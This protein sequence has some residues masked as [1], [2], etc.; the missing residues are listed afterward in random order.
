[1]NSRRGEAMKAIRVAQFGEPD[2]LQLAEVPVPMPGDGQILVRVQ[3][4]GVNPVETYIRAGSYAAQ[5][6][7]PYTPGS[8]CAGTVEAV[9]R[10]VAGFKLGDRVYTAGTISGSYAELALCQAAQVH[11]LPGNVTFAQGAAIGIPYAT[12]YRG[13]MDRAEA[14]P[15]EMVLIH[16]ASGGVGLAAVQI[17]AKHGL[18]IFA[19][20]GTTDGRQLVL[21]QGAHCVYDHGTADYTKKILADTGGRGVDIILEM[22]ANQNLGK[23]LTLLATRGRVVVIGSRGPVEINARDAMARD[24]DIRG[25]ILPNT[26]PVE[27]ARIHAALINGLESG[28]YHPVIAQELPLAAAAKAHHLIMQP[29]A[30]GKII[31]LPG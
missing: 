11:P 23:D 7:L 20:A 3:A 2:V 31:L 15:G 21:K 8:D 5:P 28:A 25:M 1:M 14:L 12:A 22:L 6:T 27:L 4:I 13:L 30:G 17:A 26:P 10:D 19:T 18:H 9:G 24:A 16:G 29:G